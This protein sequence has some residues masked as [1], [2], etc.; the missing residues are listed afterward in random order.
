ML[1]LCP[2]GVIRLPLKMA[3]WAPFQTAYEWGVKS[4]VIVGEAFEAAT[5]DVEGFERLWLI[6]WPDR[7]GPFQ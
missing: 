3:E 7:A 6:Y 4:E 1:Q 2:I 5:I